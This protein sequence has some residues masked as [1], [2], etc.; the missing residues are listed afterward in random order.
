M[1]DRAR[2]PVHRTIVLVDVEGFG[3]RHRTL[4]HQLGIRAGLYRM[5]AAALESAGVPLDA[6]YREDRGDSVFVL[7]PP[8]YPKAPLMEVLPEALARAVRGH[9][10]TSHD[11]ARVRLRLA[12]HAGEVA[13]DDHG[14]TSTAV[15]TAFRLLDATPLKQALA[16]SP[17]V[18]AMI[19]S[20]LVFDEVVRHSATL[21]PATFRPVEVAVKEIRDMAWIALPDHP[22]P[23][24]HAVLDPTTPADRGRSQAEEEP[25]TQS[26]GA[27]AGSGAN[28][29][30]NQR[31]SATNGGIAVN[32]A[33][34][35]NQTII[36]PHQTPRPRFRRGFGWALM[37]FLAVDVVFAAVVW[38]AGVQNVGPWP[39]TSVLL[40]V[41]TVLTALLW[42][43]LARRVFGGLWRAVVGLFRGMNRATEG[44][45]RTLGGK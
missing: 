39:S 25:M 23:P 35:G 40:L 13:F 4:P 19:V 22:Y 21:N 32:I 28:P 3:A 38:T 5:V 36:N 42:L 43:R 31:S 15:T 14:A 30:V 8:E 6:C 7:V 27:G 33:G 24:D 44:L 29:Q 41:L 9:N 26:H 2:H 10:N 1:A 17:G 37:V 45:T 20:R 16:D 12:V 18:L 34:T 11:A